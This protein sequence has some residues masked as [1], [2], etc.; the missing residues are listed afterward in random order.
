V[1]ILLMA[2][3]AFAASWNPAIRAIQVDPARSLREQ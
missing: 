1:A 3:V 2:V